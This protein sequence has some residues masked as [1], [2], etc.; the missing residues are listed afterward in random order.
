[1]IMLQK[2]DNQTKGFGYEQRSSSNFISIVYHVAFCFEIIIFNKY[3]LLKHDMFKLCYLWS[4]CVNK[5]YASETRHDQIM[6]FMA[7]PVDWFRK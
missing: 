1:M 5:Y 2:E 6:L 4:N 7:Q 3:Q